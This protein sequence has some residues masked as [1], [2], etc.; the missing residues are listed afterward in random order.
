MEPTP[1]GTARYQDT[2]ERSSEL[3]RLA[4]PLMSR[5]K[6]A[7]HPISYAVW[8][9]YVSGRNKPLRDEI[10]HL[11]QTQG[12]LDEDSTMALYRHYVRTPDEA[13]ADRASSTLNQ[14]IEDVAA[15]AV[16]SAKNVSNY[17]ESLEQF[18]ASLGGMADAAQMPYEVARIL[19]N[20]GELKYSI[21]TLLKSLECTRT[22]VEQ[23]R[24]QMKHNCE[25]ATT[26]ALTGLRNRK[27]FDDALAAGIELSVTE[28]VPFSFVM[29]DID[30]FKRFND[31]YGHIVGDKVL[32]LVSQVLRESVRGADTVARYGGEEFAILLPRTPLIGAKRVAEVI[33]MNISRGQLR[34]SA[35]KLVDKITASAGVASHIPGETTETFITRVD[36]ALYKSK[37]NGR[38]RVTLAESPHDLEASN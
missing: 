21:A 16:D 32:K 4:V 36:A 25:E 17:G 23:L 38:D 8:Y 9:D 18:S 33:C 26:D 31:T 1:N 34:N 2:I 35:G 3:L 24:A 15:T 14:A 28:N 19:S 12:V 7:L 5:Q 11:I 22:E 10:D 20:T 37:E 6:A 30:H 13:A 29:I 27:G